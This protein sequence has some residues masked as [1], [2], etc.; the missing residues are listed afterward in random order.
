MTSVSAIIMSTGVYI[1]NVYTYC[2]ATIP[3]NNTLL[4]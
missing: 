1:L 3:N 2:H 4:N